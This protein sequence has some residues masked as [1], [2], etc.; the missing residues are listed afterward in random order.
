MR[1]LT[2]GRKGLCWALSV[3]TAIASFI[4]TPSIHASGFIDD[5]S[6]NGAVYY[7]QRQRDRKEMNKES[8]HYGQ[9][10]PNL[11]H[12][13]V[14][15]SLDF[16]S[17]YAADIIGLDLALFGAIEMSNSG[18]ATPNEIGF[19][20]AKHRWEEEWGG[21]RSG[22]SLYKAALKMKADDYWLRA[23]YIQPQGQTLFAP[24]WSFL[25]GTYRAIEAGASSDFTDAGRLDI[26][27]MWTD[28]Y[29]A[30]WYR[31]FYTFRK[32]DGK[33]GIPWM[34]AIGARYDFKNQLILEASWGQA[35]D[36]MDQYFAKASWSMPLG[37]SALRTSYQFYGAKDHE[38]GGAANS[39]DVYDGLAWLQ[40]LTFGYVWGPFDLR[41]EGT[42]VKAEG[43]QGFFLQR[44]TPSWASSN[45][46]LDIWWD[47]RSDWNANGEKALFAGVM[48]DLAGWNLPGWAVG[49]SYAWG[50][51]AKPS[52]SPQWDQGQRLRE[53][54][55]NLDLL[56]TIQQGRAKDTLFKLHF[57]RY[58]NHS[59]IASYGGGFGN[60]FQDEKDVKFMII[61]PFTLFKQSGR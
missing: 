14:N 36:Y 16:N 4:I 21:D 47:A 35:A 26:S 42:W 20:R 17:G 34:Q 5:A 58:D 23:G 54:A 33:T 52:T 59:D 12:A 31:N 39:N 30:P 43:N 13:T 37:D 22:V 8:E 44:M 57:T 32:A 50:W 53:S 2:G 60:I 6:L 3:L 10:Q 7:W 46:R 45:G 18:P 19:S 56:Y 15:G 49:T 51:D 40:A 29:K 41:L 25:P 38:S 9:Y 61:A 24:H 28:R 11:H 27:W 1:T 55:W 48:Y